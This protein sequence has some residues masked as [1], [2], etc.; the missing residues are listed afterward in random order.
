MR[1]VTEDRAVDIRNPHAVRPWQHVL[2][3]LDGYMCLV[4]KLWGNGSK[5]GGGWNFGPNYEGCKSVAWILSTLGSLLK[6]GIRY[7]ADESDNPHEAS[8]LKLDCSKAGTLLNWE[9][10]LDLN[11]TLEMVVEWYEGYFNKE[12][13]R[14]LSERQLTWYEN[15]E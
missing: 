8:Y 12:N 4:E 7:D 13:I 14:E 2:E 10:K 1:A 15:M 6:G 11:A 3:P 9:P 5:Y